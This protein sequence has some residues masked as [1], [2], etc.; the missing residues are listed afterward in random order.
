MLHKII[1]VTVSCFNKEHVSNSC[2]IMEQAA[3]MFVAVADIVY[4]ECNE[5]SRLIRLFRILL[6]HCDGLNM[7]TESNNTDGLSVVKT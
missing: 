6:E 2:V 5:E 7:T 3:R 1:Q 4:E